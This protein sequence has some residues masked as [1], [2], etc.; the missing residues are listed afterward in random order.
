MYVRTFPKFPERVSDTCVLARCWCGSA[1]LALPA[2]KSRHPR[3][4]GAYR[5]RW[6]ALTSE[7]RHTQEEKE[8]V[9]QKEVLM[10]DT[11]HRRDGEYIWLRYSTQFTT[12]ERSHSIE[13]GIPVPIGASAEQRERLLHEAEAGMSQLASHVENR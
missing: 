6:Q 5:W 1:A 3:Q 8:Q 7:I 10:D 11:M 4:I 13:I 2:Y 9:E 12:G